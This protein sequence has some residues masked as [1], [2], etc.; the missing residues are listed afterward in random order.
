MP[1]KKVL[2]VVFLLATVLAVGSLGVADSQASNESWQGT[3]QEDFLT[4]PIVKK[5]Q[6]VTCHT[7]ADEGGT[8]GPI[9][10]QV[11]L[12]RTEDWIDTWL[13]DPN[14]VKPGTK[15]PKFPFTDEERKLTVEYLTKM[16]RDLR[17][18][19][20]LASDKP[21]FEIG[22]ELF[23]D[24][25]CLACHRIGDE[26]RFV[27]PD[28][29][30]VGIRKPEAWEQ[31]WLTSPP[32]FKPDTFMP[33]FHIPQKAVESLAAYLHTLQGQDNAAGRQWEFMFSFMVNTSAK[34]RGE[35]VWKRL[36]CWSC[37]GENGRGGIENP[38]AAPGHEL[39]PDMKGARDGFDKAAFL[40]KLTSGTETPAADPSAA[41]L[42]YDCPAYPDNAL[43]QQ[44][45][46]DLYA[47]VSSLAPPKS[48]WTIK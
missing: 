38:N 42:P 31:I 29:T 48:R 20:I 22:R 25:D 7:I 19:E 2:R 24:Y 30:W 17:T 9:L 11:G 4:G 13:Q 15:M 46:D 8:V 47:Y 33:D 16:K 40:A 43:N 37:H 26:G 10:N 1:G 36:G 39:V 14:A 3:P 34:V 45:L 41:P 23:L 44:G 5:F 12:R 28:L 27:G 21:L 35:M 32:A 18:D 6:C